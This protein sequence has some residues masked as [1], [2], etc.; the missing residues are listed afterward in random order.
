MIQSF[1]VCLTELNYA[2][3]ITTD[4]LNDFDAMHHYF[5]YYN[6]QYIALFALGLLVNAQSLREIR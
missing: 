3:F 2:V 1:S 4:V 5:K 6:I